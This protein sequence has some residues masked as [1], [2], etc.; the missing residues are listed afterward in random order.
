MLSFISPIVALRSFVLL[1]LQGDFFNA[2]V[3]L[4]GVFFIGAIYAVE[5]KLRNPNSG[6]RWLYRLLLPL[7]SVGLLNFLIYYSLLTIRSRSW[8]TR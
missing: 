6:D 2:L 5:F 8:M 3:Y 4:S 1:P 7:L